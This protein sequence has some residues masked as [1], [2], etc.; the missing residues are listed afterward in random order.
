MPFLR[1]TLVRCRCDLHLWERVAVGVSGKGT[2]QSSILYKA[3]RCSYWTADKQAY[4]KYIL[5]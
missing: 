4:S 2:Y 3:M 5:K 1:N